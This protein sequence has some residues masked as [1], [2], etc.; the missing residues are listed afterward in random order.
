MRFDAHVDSHAASRIASRRRTCQRLVFVACAWR[1]PFFFGP[2]LQC[3]SM[4]IVLVI[5]D[6]NAICCHSR[7]AIMPDAQPDSQCPSG[8]LHDGMLVS[9]RSRGPLII[10]NMSGPPQ[11]RA[12]CQHLGMRVDMCIAMCID[13]HV[14]MRAD[15][16]CRHICRHTEA[17]A[18]SRVQPCL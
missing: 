5:M 12:T 8:A 14:G 18:W 7:Y 9:S 3:Q 4:Y 1:A 2:D 6:D 17:C 13:M 15:I 11:H 10:T 16:A